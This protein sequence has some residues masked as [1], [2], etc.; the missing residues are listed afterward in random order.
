M[1]EISDDNVREALTNVEECF[2]EKTN[3]DVKAL[4][5]A[6]KIL[7][8]EYKISE[9][10]RQIQV[11]DQEN[12]VKEKEILIKDQSIRLLKNLRQTDLMKTVYIN[13]MSDEDLLTNG[14]EIFFFCSI[15]TELYISYKEWY[16][17]VFKRISRTPFIFD[18]FV[19]VKVICKQPMN[20]IKVS[21]VVKCMSLSNHLNL[22]IF[23]KD[24]KHENSNIYI[25][26]PKSIIKSIRLKEN[27]KNQNFHVWEVD[28]IPYE[29]L[30]EDNCY[31]IV[32][33][34]KDK[35]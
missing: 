35:I 25:L 13:N 15:K 9:Q 33:C 31:I 17:T 4:K 18:Q 14:V 19:L 30:D 11:K 3:V 1:A 29:Y 2:G 28:S 12:R 22:D 24:W 8:L 21:S 26:H 6:F 20:G 23:D 10:A 32:L 16:E 5:N 7:K 27:L 34:L